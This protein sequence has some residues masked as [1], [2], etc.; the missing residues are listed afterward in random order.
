MRSIILSI[1]LFCTL[2][3]FAKAQPDCSGDAGFKDK[4]ELTKFTDSLRTADSAESMSPL[5][6]YPLTVNETQKKHF[7]IKNEAELKARFEKAFSSEILKAI[8]DQD[9]KVMFCNYQGLTIGGGAVWINKKN[10]K[11]GIFV[12]NAR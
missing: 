11:T 12:V 10:G 8:H 9:P 4:Q 5:I 1:L 7:L 2:Q 3:S 6:S